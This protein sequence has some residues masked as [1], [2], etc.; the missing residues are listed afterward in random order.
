MAFAF[1]PEGMFLISLL[2]I[3]L[4][5]ARALDIFRLFIKKNLIYLVLLSKDGRRAY[6]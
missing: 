1:R 3:I 5:H 4:K 6:Y 2:R